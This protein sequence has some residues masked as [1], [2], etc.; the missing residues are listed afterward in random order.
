MIT[1]G[2]SS[3]NYTVTYRLTVTGQPTDDGVISGNVAAQSNVVQIPAQGG[4][5]AF[6]GEVAKTQA[7]IAKPGYRVRV[8]DST[9]PGINIVRA[10]GT[11]GT[12]VPTVGGNWP[13]RGIF[14]YASTPPWNH[15]ESLLC[16][17][18]EALSNGRTLYINGEW[19]YE[20]LFSWPTPTN[21]KEMRW[22]PQHSDDQVYVVNNQIR[23]FHP[24]NGQNELVPATFSGI[25]SL[26]FGIYPGAAM[27]GQISN[28]GTRMV[29]T[30]RKTSNDTVVAYMVN[31]DTGQTFAEIPLYTQ[32]STYATDGSNATDRHIQPTNSFGDHDF[33]TIS[34][35]GAYVL[36]AWDGGN[37]VVIFNAETGAVIVNTAH[38]TTIHGLKDK[39]T[40]PETIMSGDGNAEYLTF[41]HRDTDRLA[42]LTM[43]NLVVGSLQYLSAAS[44]ANITHASG[45]RQWRQ[46]SD[47]KRFM[48]GFGTRGG[49]STQPLYNTVWRCNVDTGEF[50][51][52]AHH[53]TNGS[54]SSTG[55]EAWCAISPSGTRCIFTSNWDHDKSESNGNRQWYV[56]E[57]W[58]YLNA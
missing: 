55:V 15:D 3:G 24:S 5:P 18:N 58:E 44:S 23:I 34:A 56:I 17:N 48:S 41:S 54:N 8:V 40:H 46:R 33:I 51:V 47:G 45:G 26:S 52:F 27:N 6:V 50:N 49:D 16:M 39:I 30:G 25:T 29:V 36:H 42:R 22:R 4:A 35:S 21:P 43:P 38:P 57:H 37:D 11:E 12:A 19:P 32:A 31:I 10:A 28:D 2:T 13:H 7:N 1:R 9:F 53:Y 20:P 14:Q